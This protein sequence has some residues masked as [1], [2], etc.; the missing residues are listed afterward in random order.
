MKKALVLVCLLAL[1]L[2]L[3]AQTWLSG[4]VDDALAQAKS[5]GKLLLL[6]FFASS[7]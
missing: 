3:A 4:S 7:G 1:P 2:S 5:Q 6:D